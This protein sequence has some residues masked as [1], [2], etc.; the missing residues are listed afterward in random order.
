MKI[1]IDKQTKIVLLE[2]ISTGVLDTL[3][4]PQL[5][6]KEQLS[7]FHDLLAEANQ[8]SPDEQRN[9]FNNHSNNFNFK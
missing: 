7:F 6:G 4:I 5:Y 8:V 1:V 3:R 9:F 2:A